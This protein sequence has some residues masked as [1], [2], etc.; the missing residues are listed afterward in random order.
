MQ[1]PP[2]SSVS[3]PPSTPKIKPKT[4]HMQTWGLNLSEQQK[5]LA[6][7]LEIESNAFGDKLVPYYN[8]IDKGNLSGYLIMNQTMINDLQIIAEK[9]EGFIANWKNSL[10]TGDRCLDLAL[11]R[12][13]SSG[14]LSN[15]IPCSV[16]YR[17]LLEPAA[18][19]ENKFNQVISAME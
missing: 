11:L 8:P 10:R 7:I 19:K 12:V 6:K 17:T 18:L 14:E 2:T 9:E 1:T 13:D 5:A 16:D 3:P 15:C 4:V